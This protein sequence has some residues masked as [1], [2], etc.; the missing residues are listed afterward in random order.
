MNS[1]SDITCPLENAEKQ[2]LVKRVDEFIKTIHSQKGTF[3]KLYENGKTGSLLKERRT[4]LTAFRKTISRM[5]EGIGLFNDPI[6]LAAILEDTGYPAQALFSDVNTPSMNMN[7][8]L[9]PGTV[10]SLEN[11]IF[12]AVQNAQKPIT[13]IAKLEKR[14]SSAGEVHR[15]VGWFIF[16]KNYSLAFFFLF[17]DHSKVKPQIYKHWGVENNQMEY[18]NNLIIFIFKNLFSST[19]ESNNFGKLLSLAYIV[20]EITRTCK[21]LI[22][23]TNKKKL[24]TLSHQTKYE[25]FIFPDNYSCNKLEDSLRTIKKNTEKIINSAIKNGNVIIPDKNET[26]TGLW[27]ILGKLLPDNFKE[28]FS[29]DTI[30]QE[31]NLEFVLFSPKGINKQIVRTRLIC[32]IDN[33]F[34]STMEKSILSI[35]EINEANINPASIKS[36]KDNSTRSVSESNTLEEDTL[37]EDTLEE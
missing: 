3:E 31:I 21:S 32:K 34:I 10:D 22:V 15:L 19:F 20:F 2:L 35:K 8:V 36:D 26:I 37:E 18:I 33:D 30:S 12:R 29:H 27:T 23:Y 1:E 16:T 4:K 24:K 25:G 6:L 9:G 13:R 28:V 11:I 5:R 14:L 7:L 17:W